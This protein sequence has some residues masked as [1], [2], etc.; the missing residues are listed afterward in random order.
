VNTLNLVAT[1]YDLAVQRGMMTAKTRGCAV[2][3]LACPGGYCVC[4]Y[5]DDHVAEVVAVIGETGV[6]WNK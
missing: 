1:S 4:P 3:L 5:C 2:Y 6:I